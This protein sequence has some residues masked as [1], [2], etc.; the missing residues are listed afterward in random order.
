MIACMRRFVMLLNSNLNLLSIARE[1]TLFFASVL[2]KYVKE[3][4]LIEI[5]NENWHLFDAQTL[6]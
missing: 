5:K 2:S 4:K 6:Q 1:L 3:K